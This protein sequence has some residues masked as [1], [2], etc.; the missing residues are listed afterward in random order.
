MV[1]KQESS[2]VWLVSSWHDSNDKAS[3]FRYWVSQDR[4]LNLPAV[5]TYSLF[6]Q[7]L[8]TWLAPK[9]RSMFFVWDYYYSPTWNC[10]ILGWNSHGKKFFFG[11]MISHGKLARSFASEF[12]ILLPSKL[13]WSNFLNFWWSNA[14]HPIQPQCFLNSKSFTN[15]AQCRHPWFLRN[16]TNEACCCD[17]LLWI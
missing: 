5:C 16:G 6:L 12:V 2:I 1:L 7:C 3:Q 14:K 4:H 11:K 10:D 15:S 9:D 13:N 17:R 8:M